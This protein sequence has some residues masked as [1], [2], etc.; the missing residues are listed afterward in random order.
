M[1]LSWGVAY[2]FSQS[3]LKLYLL[4]YLVK[5]GFFDFLKEGNFFGFNGMISLQ[6]E[7]EF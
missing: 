5:T 6:Y 3:C 1:L 4:Y 2:N 7:M